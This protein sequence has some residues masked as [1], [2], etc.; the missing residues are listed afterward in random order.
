MQKQKQKKQ[1]QN[2]HTSLSLEYMKA[3][4]IVHGGISGQVNTLK[5]AMLLH[6]S[7]LKSRL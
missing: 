2:K 7:S 3:C 6:D 4:P 1:K 5:T